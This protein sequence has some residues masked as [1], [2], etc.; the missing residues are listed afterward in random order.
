MKLSGIQYMA[1]LLAAVWAL[2]LTACTTDPEGVAAGGEEDYL[3]LNILKE[4]TR[5]NLDEDGSGTFSEGDCI[6]LYIDNGTRRQY[7]ELTLQGGEWTPRLKRSEFGTER[8][9]LSAHYPALSDLDEATADHHAF[10]IE[11]DQ[12]GSGRDASDLL[13]SQTTVESGQYRADLPFRHALHR[14]RI[15][16]VGTSDDTQLT[17]R[18]RTNGWINL[19]TGQAEASEGTI[20]GI[21]PHANADGSFEAVIFPQEAD[22]YRDGDGVLL[23]ISANGQEY[24]FKAPATQSDSSP[25]ERFEAGKQITI[26]LTLKESGDAEWKNR[27]VWV[28]GL[29]APED[30]SV[31]TQLFPEF[32]TTYYLPWKAEYGW[33]DCNKV[34]PENYDNGVPDGSMCWAATASNL[35]HWWIAQNKQYVD[36]YGDKYKGPDYTY[37]LPKTQES[38]I[39]QCFVDSFQDEGGLGDAGVNWFIHGEI[40]S[41]P[42]QRYPYNPGGYFKDVFPEGVRLGENIGGLGREKFNQ[43]IKDALAN[44]KSIGISTGNI[45]SSHLLTVWG[46]EFDENGEVAYLYIAD[47]NDRDTSEKYGVGCGRYQV[48]YKEY[49]EGGTYTCYSTGDIGGGSGIVITRIVTLDLGEKYWK[50]YLGL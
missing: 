4:E 33:Y 48:L 40:P 25:L 10:S 17:V 15:E 24:D 6:G 13:V 47:N 14:L 50:Q 43:T 9:T 44:R 1:A 20:E 22:A 26:K 29:K 11:T 18:S 27:T 46:A 32:Y 21:T 34:N 38:D 2:L 36:M 42:A 31:W 8:L 37:P 30:P 19:L 3:Q 28:Y 5:A 23:K 35:L 7:R 45:R 39:F 49:P 12:S 41:Y 16:L